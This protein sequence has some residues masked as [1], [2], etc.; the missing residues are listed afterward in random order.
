MSV[1]QPLLRKRPA[2]ARLQI[3]LEGEGSL[4]VGKCHVGLQSPRGKLGRVSDLTRVVPFQAISQIK[5]DADIEVICVGFAL[6]DV[7]VVQAGLRT[8]VPVR[9]P[10]AGAG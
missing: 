2:R 10:G 4:L 7:Y 8:A 6:E 1:L 9:L 3:P 5:S